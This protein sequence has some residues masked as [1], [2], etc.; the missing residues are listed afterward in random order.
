MSG[1]KRYLNTVFD[2]RL[3]WGIMALFCLVIVLMALFVPIPEDAEETA[4]PE[5]ISYEDG[6]NTQALM[7]AN[8]QES[9]AAEA[10]YQIKRVFHTEDDFPKGLRIKWARAQGERVLV[11][12]EQYKDLNRSYNRDYIAVYDVSGAWLYGFEG[13]LH[14]ESTRIALMPDQEGILFWEWKMKSTEKEL[15]LV[16]HPDGHKQMHVTEDLWSDMPAYWESDYEVAQTEESRL[17][18]VHTDTGKPSVVFDYSDAYPTMYP[19]SS[20]IDEEQEMM[21]NGLVPIIFMLIIIFLLP[22]MMDNPN[23]PKRGMKELHGD[24]RD[25]Q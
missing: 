21:L 14:Y 12:F 24:L 17:V 5:A 16:V 18:I 23:V 19:R 15:F 7:P 10:I 1:L 11:V 13:V 9:K 25:R 8:H 20:K 22:W 4:R 6:W 2:D 3:F